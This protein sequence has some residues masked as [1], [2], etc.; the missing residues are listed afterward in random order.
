MAGSNNAPY[1]T[2]IIGSASPGVR[3]QFKSAM[4]K[5]LSSDNHVDKNVSFA[6]V[7]SKHK[8]ILSTISVF[9]IYD[10]F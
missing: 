2:D 6:L 3:M 9:F 10:R 4:G 7:Q 1:S 8:R 5:T